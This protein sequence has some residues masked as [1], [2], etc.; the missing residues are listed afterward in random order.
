VAFVHPENVPSLISL[1]SAASLFDV[2]K[3]L[4]LA[5]IIRV[6]SVSFAAMDPSY[7]AEY[8]KDLNIF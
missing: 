7:L 6:G 4:G 8:M 5:K 2:H 1:G 3:M